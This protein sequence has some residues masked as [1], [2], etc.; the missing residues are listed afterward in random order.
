MKG[1]GRVSD[2]LD[3][4]SVA[5]PRLDAYDGLFWLLWC[6]WYAVSFDGL[7]PWAKE[8]SR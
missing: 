5:I 8:R 7:H 6:Q 4:K 1:G 2:R 3:S